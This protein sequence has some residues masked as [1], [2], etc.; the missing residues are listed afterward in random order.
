MN[1]CIAYNTLNSPCKFFTYDK[2]T[3]YCGHHKSKEY[4]EAMI[5]KRKNKTKIYWETNKQILS[6]KHKIYYEKNKDRLLTKYECPCGSNISKICLSR[7]IASNKHKD[8]V[9]I[10]KYSG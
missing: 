3:E 1:K 10:M 7:H 4:Y 6:D 8:Y 2:N 9:E 5:L